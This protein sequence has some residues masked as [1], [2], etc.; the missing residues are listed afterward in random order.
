[1]ASM[2]LAQTHDA[3][4][5]GPALDLEGGGEVVGGR[6]GSGRVVRVIGHG[7]SSENG[8]TSGAPSDRRPYR[9]W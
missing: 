4:A 8:E 6:G 7:R 1:M 5:H 2:V 9:E 3:A